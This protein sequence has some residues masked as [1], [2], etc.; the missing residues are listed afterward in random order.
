MCDGAEDEI[1]RVLRDNDEMEQFEIE[2]L[3]ANARVRVSGQKQILKVERGR[4]EILWF[5]FQEMNV[6]K[7]IKRRRRVNFRCFV[8]VLE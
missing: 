3:G 8:P 2:H 5:E 1:E 6:F 4:N 7:S